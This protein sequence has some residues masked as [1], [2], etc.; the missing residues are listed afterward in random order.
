MT[1]AAERPGAGP[2]ADAVCARRAGPGVGLGQL[3]VIAVTLLAAAC[4]SA[5]TVSLDTVPLRSTALL[6]G[7]TTIVV[8][9]GS[10]DESRYC[11]ALK[12]VLD[13]AQKLT[14]A[15][16]AADIKAALATFSNG[17]AILAASGPASIRTTMSAAKDSAAGFTTMLDR[18]HY[19]LAAAARDPEYAALTSGNAIGLAADAA[20]THYT[21]D[22]GG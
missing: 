1:A 16:A 9:R 5:K 4:S 19:D 15:K 10:L 3:V 8:D 7:R 20:S 18:N 21:D 11:S 6:P 14:A 12:D 2:G 13:S 22:C 17:T